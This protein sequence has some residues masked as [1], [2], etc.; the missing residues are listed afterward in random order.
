MEKFEP[1]IRFSDKLTESISKLYKIGGLG[2]V[3][4]FLGFLSVLF[5]FFYPEGKLSLPL[6]VIGGILL[7]FSFL[8]FII[9]QYKI[10]IKARGSLTK[11]K[12]IVDGVQD[13]SI[14]LTKLT[15][16]T[17]AFCFKHI[18]EIQDIFK[19][20]TPLVKPFLGEKGN[21]FVF[22]IESASG[23]IVEY[24][25]SIEQMILEIQEALEK[26]DFSKFENYK[27][28]L[29]KLNTDIQKALKK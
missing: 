19:Q 25:K 6:F 15:Y 7:V 5:S 23:N 27:I 28:E 3:F 13:I 21:S 9:V 24:A 26:G 17:Q 11:N 2:L 10:P 16:N 20:L 22:K 14:A 4:I 8:I 29:E 12:G 1:P 18:K